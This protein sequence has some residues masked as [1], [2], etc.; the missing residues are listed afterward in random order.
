MIWNRKLYVREDSNNGDY[1]ERLSLGTSIIPK[2]G[3]REFQIG[4]TVTP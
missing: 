4:A 2:A 1:I 3:D